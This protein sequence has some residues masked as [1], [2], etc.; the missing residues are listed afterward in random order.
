MAEVRECADR[1][2]VDMINFEDDNLFASRSAPKPYW[3]ELAAF[4]DS[5]GRHLDCTA[6]NGVSLENLDEDLLPLMGR[7]GFANSH[8]THEP[9]SG[10]AEAAGQALR[11]EP[12]RQH[13]PARH[14]ASA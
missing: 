13:R 12:V 14:G 8:I 1:F 11:I 10:A 6:M 9:F 5:S 7:A 2:G 3:G 4:Q